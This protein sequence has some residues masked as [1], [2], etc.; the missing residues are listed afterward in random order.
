MNSAYAINTV[1]EGCEWY[2]KAAMQGYPLI[3]FSVARCHE[4]GDFTG[5]K[6]FVMAYAWHASAEILH[7]GESL[8]SIDTQEYGSNSMAAVFMQRVAERAKLTPEQIKVALNKAKEIALQIQ[9]NVK[10]K[11]QKVSSTNSTSSQ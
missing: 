10:A 6:D 2:L 9:A 4:R 8:Y 1:R 7:A 3:A 11:Q 5:K